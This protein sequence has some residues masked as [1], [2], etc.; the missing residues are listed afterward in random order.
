MRQQDI[1]G[2]LRFQQQ[3]CLIDP[4]TGHTPRCAFQQIGIFKRLQEVSTIHVISA[5]REE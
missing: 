4:I 5:R 2:L 3:S 1:N